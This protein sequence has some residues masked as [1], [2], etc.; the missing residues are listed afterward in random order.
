MGV[1][2]D[3]GTRCG[4]KTN[5][6]LYKSLCTLIAHLASYAAD[7]VEALDNVLAMAAYYQ[8]KATETCGGRLGYASARLMKC[9]CFGNQIAQKTHSYFP[10]A[11]HHAKKIINTRFGI[12]TLAPNKNAHHRSL[13]TQMVG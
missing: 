6:Q 13:N 3:V 1:L 11:L 7:S 9:N 8:I 4:I 5:A 12:L 2:E 10:I